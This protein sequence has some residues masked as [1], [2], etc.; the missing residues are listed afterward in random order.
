MGECDF[1][2]G[3]NFVARQAGLGIL[4]TAYLVEFLHTT[5]CRVYTE[6]WAKQ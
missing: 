3:M 4:E 5:V 6:C 2:H 1:G